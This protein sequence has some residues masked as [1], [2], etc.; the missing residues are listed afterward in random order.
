MDTNRPFRFHERSQ[1]FFGTDDEPLLVAMR[2]NDPDHSAF[3]INCRDP[4]QAPSGLC[5]VCLLRRLTPRWV[6]DERA[7]VRLIGRAWGACRFWTSAKAA[8]DKS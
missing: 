7:P 5:S 8:L 6:N 4:A 2:V 1:F 3:S